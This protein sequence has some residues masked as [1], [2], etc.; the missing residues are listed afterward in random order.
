MYK[1][2]NFG[3]TKTSVEK[4]ND[5]SILY[6]NLQPLDAYP[7]EVTFFLD[8]WSAEKPDHVFLAERNASSGNWEKLTYQQAEHKAGLI[9]R[10]FLQKG[11]ERESTVIIL[12]ENSISNALI[13]LGALKAG[14]TYTHI[15]PAYSLKSDSLE[16]LNHC[17]EQLKPH[18][19]FA[20]DGEK[21]GHALSGIKKQLPEISIICRQNSPEINLNDLLKGEP[22]ERLPKKENP[23]AKILFTSGSTGF[24]KGVIIH[25]S[26]WTASLTQITQSL[27]FMEDRPPVFVDWL[28][29]HHTFG[30]NHNF[31]L[32]LMHGGTLYIDGGIP[33][34]NGIEL[35]VKNLRGISPTAYFNVPKGFEILLDYLENDAELAS[36]FFKNLEMLFYAG[37]G[38]AQPVWD[39]WEALAIKTIG[40][41]IPIIS[42][43]GCT[44]AGPSA[45]FA[46]W[47]G[48]FSGCLGVP[49]PGLDVK[50]TPVNDKLEA[51]YKGPNITKGYWKTPE[52]NAES[53]D[54]EGFYKSGDAVKFLDAI[55]PDKGLVFDGR[56]K[57]DFKLSSGT[58]VSVGVIRQKL[59]SMGDPIIHD[60]VLTGLN[61]NFIG[62]LI[63]INHTACEK[64]EGR[65]LT[66]D[67]LRSA[68]KVNNFINET[69]AKFNSES[70]GS[71][72]NILK[73]CIAPEAPSAANGEITDK[74]S[75]NQNKI[76]KKHDI[77]ITQ[78]FYS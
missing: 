70:K 36:S 45:M 10:Y 72:T 20:E 31:G 68:K 8:Q 50:L 64:L 9:A 65:P 54:E 13:T 69:L 48:A 66:Y 17:V 67:E 32:T 73:Y 25:H 3:P 77:F 59:I 39:R 34:P 7:K 16:K 14:L 30:G 1:K 61:Q 40:V 51:R 46:N 43:L 47:P 2:V 63:F 27:P 55:N 76:L 60:V 62:A 58:W 78:T 44:E 41:K 24:P 38:L 22:A 18:F 11:F 21:F 23:I 12:S 71:S 56:I 6:R 4:R 57:E 33:S 49:V 19:V 26:M 37:A 35:T 75:I 74:G 52:V 5:G 29:W 42:G 28:P 15:S 53:F